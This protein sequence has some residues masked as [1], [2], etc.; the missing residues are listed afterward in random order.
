M[1]RKTATAYT[2]W[3]LGA[4]AIAL[5]GSIAGCD[6]AS[7]SVAQTPIEAEELTIEDSELYDQ[8]S[9]G[10]PVI[11]L[12]AITTRSGRS[13]Q[14]N[15]DSE[16]KITRHAIISLDVVSVDVAM[17]QL[18]AVTVELGGYVSSRGR[19]S[20]RRGGLSGKLL[21]RI[22]AVKMDTA[23]TS[24]RD[25]G[26]FRDEHIWIEDITDNYHDTSIRLSNAKVEHTKLQELLG[27]AESVSNVL[28]V[29]RELNRVA[30]EIERTTGRKRRLDND[31]DY[32]QIRVHMMESPPITEDPGTV[33]G[34]IVTALGDMVDVFWSTVA[35]IIKFVGFAVPMVIVLGALYMVLRWII[36]R[37][38]RTKK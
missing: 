19:A 31:I 18:T 16:R 10:Q 22:P 36:R 9:S 23:I 3:R 35:G 1:T 15:T 38:M 6:T 2:G 17:E 25:L 27:R 20:D 12:S 29:R 34:K 13:T 33:V 14:R 30:T 5:L 21:L 11:E 24:I 37:R 28:A 8:A 7:D 4:I 32:S 26:E